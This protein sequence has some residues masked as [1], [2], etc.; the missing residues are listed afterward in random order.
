MIADAEFWIS[1]SVFLVPDCDS[2]RGPDYP[3][4]KFFKTLLKNFAPVF[5]RICLC[6]NPGSSC[7]SRFL[8]RARV[9]GLVPEL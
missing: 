2:F 6:D 8:G 9:S 3:L 7:T 1:P 4:S 5:H